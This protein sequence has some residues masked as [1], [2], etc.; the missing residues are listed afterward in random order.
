MTDKMIRYFLLMD[1]EIKKTEMII[2][3]I[4]QG[5]LLQKPGFTLITKKSVFTLMLFCFF[6]FFFAA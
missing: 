5:K 2:Y 4:F 1:N 6:I 3:S